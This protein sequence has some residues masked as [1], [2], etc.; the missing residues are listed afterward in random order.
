MEKIESYC[1]NICIYH[2]RAACYTK[3]ID[4]Y[5]FGLFRLHWKKY[6][7]VEQETRNF[8]YKSQLCPGGVYRENFVWTRKKIVILRVFRAV[9]EIFHIFSLLGNLPLF[10]IYM[11]VC[12]G[13]DGASPRSILFV[14]K[15]VFDMKIINVSLGETIVSCIWTFPKTHNSKESNKHLILKNRR[16][17]ATW[18]GVSGYMTFKTKLRGL[19]MRKIWWIFIKLSLNKSFSL[20]SKNISLN[21]FLFLHGAERYLKTNLPSHYSNSA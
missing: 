13:S 4:E 1:Q 2:S 5:F 11:P 14:R 6:S 10:F 21:T 17:Y 18:C 12:R 19:F 9:G 8:L 7:F 20:I 3:V 16:K 15:K